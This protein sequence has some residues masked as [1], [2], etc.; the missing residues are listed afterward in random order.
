[1][2]AMD[3]F[4]VLE[5][6]RKGWGV[7]QDEAPKF[8]KDVGNEQIAVPDEDRESVMYSGGAPYRKPTK[9]E[10]NPATLKTAVESVVPQDAVDLGLMA[11]AG[12]FGKA[13][14]TGGAALAGAGYSGE[15]EASPRTDAA[16]RI[17]KYVASL[18]GDKKEIKG[19][20]S[21]T[22]LRG[23]TQDADAAIADMRAARKAG[24]KSAGIIIRETEPLRFLPKTDSPYIETEQFLP[25][26]MEPRGGKYNARMADLLDNKAAKK[27]IE[28]NMLRG[29]HM[30][31]QEWYG[32]APLYEAAMQEGLSKEEFGR[33]M[34][35]L[36]NA[37]QRSPVPGQIKRGSATWV[38]DKNG[39]LLPDSPEYKLPPGYGSLAQKQIIE[40]AKRIAAGEGMD[41]TKKLGR[42]NENLGGNLD[43]VTVDVMAMRGPT[44]ATKDPRWL[45]RE[46]REKNE[47]T[48]EV[49][50]TRPR[51]MYDKGELTVEEALKRPG[52]WEAAPQGSE[53]GGFEDLYTGLA[54]KHGMRPAEGQA[55]AWY[56]SGTEAGL[57]TQPRTFMQA[58]EDRIAE[59]AAKRNETPQQVLRKML[60]GEMP[61]M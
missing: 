51:E 12:P 48:G 55:T 20:P 46:I 30:G 27:A 7:I 60:R 9:L 2:G 24:D 50:I 23:V 19:L 16:K 5:G 21:L 59:T 22:S 25:P 6:L 41:T 45:A 17:G 1:M 10:G 4:N 56:G 37:S 18:A 44:M 31:M 36:S 29:Q 15:A 47:K 8:W 26:R 61:L 3:K 39:L 53:Y 28:R 33:M 42:F 38:A 52:F 13:V 57:R 54:K 34:Q 49:T 35:H 43:P 32:T 58:V 40:N 14:K 11:V